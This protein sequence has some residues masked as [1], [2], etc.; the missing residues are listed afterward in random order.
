MP[1]WLIRLLRWILEPPASLLQR[2]L[3]SEALRIKLHTQAA[4]VKV[5]G[6]KH[7]GFR[8]EFVDTG[9]GWLLKVYSPCG[10]CSTLT[11]A[12]TATP[13]DLAKMAI[14]VMD[15]VLGKLT[16][17]AEEADTAQ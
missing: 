9:K 8:F 15:E 1:R 13:D 5:L 14:G 10:S 16:L 12:Q 3:H 2:I 4:W 6:A 11:K 17:P 7:P